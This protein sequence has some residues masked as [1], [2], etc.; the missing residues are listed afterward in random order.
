[1]T[2][3]VW[4]GLVLTLTCAVAASPTHRIVRGDLSIVRGRIVAL[5][6]QRIILDVGDGAQHVTIPM[7]DVPA[8]LPAKA[9]AAQPG[10][11]LHLVDG[12]VLPGSPALIASSQDDMI[13]WIHPAFGQIT[14]PLDQVRAVMLDAGLPGE[15]GDE[16]R[17]TL[18]NG[19][20]LTG[21]VVSISDNVHIEYNGHKTQIP[22]DRVVAIVLA[23]PSAQ[24]IGSVA[25]LADDTI[26]RIAS[27][28]I[29]DDRVSL[30]YDDT[31]DI[32]YALHDL[33]ACVTDA[34][35]WLPLAQ[36]EPDGASTPKDRPF[37]PLPTAIDP[38]A[39]LGLSDILISGPIDVRYKLPAGVQRFAAQ[40]VL[41]A[42]CSAWGSFDAVL[43][44]NDAE[45]FRQRL[46]RDH[47]TAAVNLPLTADAL[48]IRIEGGEFGPIQDRLLI[49]DAMFLLA[50]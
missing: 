39:P 45:V 36:F 48:T 2:I 15:V 13:A 43:L 18:I 37:S 41:P 17:V 35:A 27:I 1:M 20:E 23:N 28:R 31:H 42:E 24:L 11:S 46:D 44:V 33:I 40:L 12:Q 25:Y 49:R 5:D 29:E 9:T 7:S 21:F 38:D 14:I 22:M 47:R 50:P 32:T 30:M 19:D 16:D 6:G 3:G 4:I 10:P 8:V 26:V 34:E